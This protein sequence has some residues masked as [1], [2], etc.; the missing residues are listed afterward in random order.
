VDCPERIAFVDCQELGFDSILGVLFYLLAVYAPWLYSFLYH[1]CVIRFFLPFDFILDL[2]EQFYMGNY[3]GGV[4]P[5]S[6]MACF[7]VTLVPNIF[8]AIFLGVLIT[9][10]LLIFIPRLIDCFIAL[11]VLVRNT[12]SPLFTSSTVYLVGDVENTGG[13]VPNSSSTSDSSPVINEQ[14]G[15][16]YNAGSSSSRRRT[17]LVVRPA[18]H[19]SFSETIHGITSALLNTASDLWFHL[20]PRVKRD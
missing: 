1:G 10:V 3:P 15:A 5:P 13:I 19:G 17:P 9:G 12:F 8:P 2:L 11:W 6:F 14:I 4:F 16:E 20:K 7:Y 18:K